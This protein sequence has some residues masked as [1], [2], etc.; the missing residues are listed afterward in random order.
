MT[1]NPVIRVLKASGENEPFSEEKIRRSLERV[2]VEGEFQAKV[3]D[4][5]RPKIHDG[6]TTDQIYAEVSTLLK[7]LKP[8]FAS[9]YH[10]KK[11][12][13]ELGP[14][15]YSFEKFFAGVLE[16][17]GYKTAVGQ[18][19]KGRCI[20]HEVDIMAE[21]GR[22]KMMV[23]CKFHHEGGMR[24]DVKDTLYTYARFLD[25]K[26][27]QVRFTQAWLVTNTKATS[28]AIAYANCVGLKII[29][30]DYPAARP[31]STWVEKED[32]YPITVLSSISKD[33]K[34]ALLREGI[35][36][37]HDLLNNNLT[38]LPNQVLEKA[39][40]EVKGVLGNSE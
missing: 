40:M 36:F 13:M 17:Y 29:S 4:H 7:R 20:L 3:L 23:E 25:L 1:L 22:Q 5:L 30:W 11:A 21:K 19:R 15:G 12:I 27:A 8:P 2:G 10:L 35:V 37:C 31:L 14:A 33:E 28:E 18:F 39:V 16:H 34:Q 6:M 9:K 26:K 38:G 32:L 24:S